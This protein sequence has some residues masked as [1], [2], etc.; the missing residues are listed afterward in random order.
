LYLAKEF[1]ECGR[2]ER[3]R[4]REREREMEKK[5]KLTVAYDYFAENLKNSL[6]I[7]SL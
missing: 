6:R 7:E 5:M 4:E 2:K 1:V 3:E